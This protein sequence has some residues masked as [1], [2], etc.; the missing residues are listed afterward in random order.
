MTMLRI[1]LL[2]LALTDARGVAA[3]ASRAISPTS[4]VQGVVVKWGTTEPV[5]KATV[6]LRRLESGTPAPYIAT[7]AAD[8]TFVFGAVPPGQYRVLV[9]RPGYVNAEYGQRRPNGLGLTIGL[10]AGQ[11]ATDV[12]L[13]MT[14]TAAISGRVH[15]RF[16]RPIGNVEVQALKATY[17]DGRRMLTRV[18]SVQT[19]DRGEYRLFWLAP[20]SYFVSARHPEVP[21]SL[22]SRMQMF[23]MGVRTF[24]PG[25]MVSAGPDAPGEPSGSPNVV[26]IDVSR[27]TGDRDV[28]P[29]FEL[30]RTEKERYLT[31]YF[32]GATD[33]ASASAL[34]LTA[35]AESTGVD[36]AIDPVPV[37]RVR[38]K[39]VYESSGEPARSA[40]LQW[41]SSSGAANTD[42]DPFSL[43]SQQSVD[44]EN[45]SFDLGLVPGSYTMVAA[46][47]N[48]IGRVDIQV[49]YADLEDVTIPVSQG[50][51][52]SGRV[53]IEGR[54]AT[55]ADLAALRISLAMDPVVPGLA[56]TSYSLVLPN[57]TLT[58]A[59]GRGDFRVGVAPILN[60]PGGPRFGPTRTAVPPGLQNAYLKAIRL[61]NADVLNAGLH[62]DR[63]PDVPLEIVIGTTPGVLDGA[64]VNE[65]RQ[66]VPNATVA[67]LP[68]AA[69]RSRV[70]LFKSAVA[71]ASGRFRLERI[72]PGDYVVFACD[73]VENGEWQN[74]DFL[75]AYERRG[76]PV[77]IGDGAQASVDLLASPR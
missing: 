60:L 41:L 61:G 71:D 50:F 2:A 44:S 21:G 39:V 56:P 67:L 5:A 25:P 46:V 8:G 4:S 49:G 68:D 1:V 62:L 40:K 6:E 51:D 26:G 75:R 45:G 58:L 24:G 30:D 36:F 53:A 32:P 27:G 18:D 34:D 66:P 29:R 57:G 54:A 35:G 55:S 63:Q 17:Q 3:Q 10:A 64:V 22:G 20:G 15:D 73:D 33:E 72:P 7:T 74:P 69:R 65:N 43:Q 31:I 48:L 59:A 19:D 13:Q 52:L 42:G 14:A 12:R 23:A 47:N 16:D 9:V 77:R 28:V 76:T 38:G 37:Q 70:D 11:A